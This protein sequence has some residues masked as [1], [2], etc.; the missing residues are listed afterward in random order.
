MP[1]TVANDGYESRL[2]EELA[3][4]RLLQSISLQLIADQ[5]IEIL[6]ECLAA[7][8]ATLLRSDFASMQ[9]LHPERNDGELRLIAQ[10]G[11]SDEAAANCT[12][13]GPDSPT[14]GA[15]LR[16]A[17]RVI[18][19]DVEQCDF[20]VGTESLAQF[21]QAGIRAVQST[22][23]FSRDGQLLGMLSTHWREVH[24]PSEHQWMLF[25]ILARQAADLLE[26]RR[27]EDKLREAYDALE[28]RVVERTR[29]VR[30]LLGRLVSRQEAERRRIAREIHDQLGQ[31]MTGLRLN[32]ELLA[33]NPS[34]EQHV[35]TQQ[36]AERLDRS[37][38]FLAWEL[39]PAAIEYVGLPQ[40]LTAL[41]TEW[42]QRFRIPAECHVSRLD[43]I[44]FE[45][46]VAS[47]AYRLVQEA[48][49]NVYKH[50]KATHVHVRVDRHEDNVVIA[51]MDDGCGF[52][53]G[54]AASETATH[55]GLVGMRERSALIGGE[56]NIESSPDQG[57]AVFLRIPVRDST[58]SP[59]EL[60]PREP[61]AETDQRHERH[62]RRRSDAPDAKRRGAPP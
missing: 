34:P 51:V 11:F 32:I 23:L 58:L 59:S 20:I 44:Q 21:R 14:V 55:L 9:M 4:T 24:S 45:L 54:D 36:L 18:I 5:P 28:E 35:L 2:G 38:D 31:E 40:A 26:R 61:P 7:A 46:D 16:A 37:I 39:R 25:D 50:A 30:D 13:V 57:T 8:A 22:P 48:L 1:E 52:V 15:A 56:L 10:R 53:P 33:T 29:Q 42:S 6:Y 19:P 12:W 3:Y 17:Q 49:H 27:T 47:N 43:G 60:P 62:G 41:V